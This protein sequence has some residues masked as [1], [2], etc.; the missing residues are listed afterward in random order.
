MDAPQHQKAKWLSELVAPVVWQYS[1]HTVRDSFGIRGQIE[2]YVDQYPNTIEGNYMCSFAVTN[3]PQDETIAIVIKTL[4]HAETIT[5][6]KTPYMLSHPRS[7][8]QR[9]SV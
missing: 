3:I 2:E 5:K 7:D 9:T 1:M 6:P 4:F 8:F